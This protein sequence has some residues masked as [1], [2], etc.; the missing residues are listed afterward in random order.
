MNRVELPLDPLSVRGL[1]TRRFFNFS[2]RSFILFFG[3][4]SKSGPPPRICS[5]SADG[6]FRF[7]SRARSRFAEEPSCRDTQRWDVMGCDSIRCDPILFAL[8][9]A[10]SLV[11][12]AEGARANGNTRKEPGRRARTHKKGSREEPIEIAT[13]GHLNATRAQETGAT[14]L[15]AALPVARSWPSLASSIVRR[16]GSPSLVS[17]LRLMASHFG[18]LAP[19]IPF[20]LLSM[21]HNRRA[22]IYVIIYSRSLL[23]TPRNRAQQRQ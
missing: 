16:P 23:T 1:G 14:R 2:L 18:S 17:S 19:Q 6:I 20:L 3:C 10:G 21:Q 4:V 7:H 22:R 13:R 8:L 5:R 11:C 12:V 15:L 9:C